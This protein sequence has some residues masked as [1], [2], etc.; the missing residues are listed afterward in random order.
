M[1]LQTNVC[2]TEQPKTK[3][4]RELIGKMNKCIQPGLHEKVWPN[5]F[6]EISKIV[7]TK[8]RPAGTNNITPITITPIKV[9]FKCVVVIML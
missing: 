7:L 4:R 9:T 6:F 5:R 2:D 8:V 3:Y 1:L